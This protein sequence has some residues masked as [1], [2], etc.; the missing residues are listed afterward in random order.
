MSEALESQMPRH[1]AKDGLKIRGVQCREKSAETLVFL[2]VNKFFSAV[3]FY[4]SV[5]MCSVLWVETMHT[6]NAKS[7]SLR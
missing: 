6:Q 4:S 3:E 5:L 2:P 1:S 7:G